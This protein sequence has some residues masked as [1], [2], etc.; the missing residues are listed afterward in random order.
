MPNKA[1]TFTITFEGIRLV[2]EGIHVKS[3]SEVDPP[4]KECFEIDKV[5][6]CGENILDLVEA[7]L[8]KIAQQIFEEHIL[9]FTNP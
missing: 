2:C 3:N 4:E 1:T 5:F 8:P 7:H 6:H 9:K